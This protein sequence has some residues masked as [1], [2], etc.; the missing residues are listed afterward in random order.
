MGCDIQLA[1]ES[2]A[3]LSGFLSK[4]E[5]YKMD[6]PK[7]KGEGFLEFFDDKTYHIWDKNTEFPNNFKDILLRTLRNRIIIPSNILG[8]ATRFEIPQSNIVDPIRKQ[9]LDLIDGEI[10][11]WTFFNLEN[12]KSFYLFILFYMFA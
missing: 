4:E 2:G 7:W 10:V 11:L 6:Y 5:F 8:S 9:L 12:F 3:K 1:K